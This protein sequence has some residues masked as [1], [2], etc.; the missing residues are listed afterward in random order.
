LTL[1]VNGRIIVVG[2][3]S[4]GTSG[5]CEEDFVSSYTRI[6]NYLQWIRENSDVSVAGC[7][8]QQ[9]HYKKKF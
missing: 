7:S 8:Q 6:S 4:S 5:T 9:R 1:E 2:V 3:L